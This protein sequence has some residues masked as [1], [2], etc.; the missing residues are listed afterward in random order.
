MHMYI[1]FL[2]MSEILQLHSGLDKSLQSLQPYLNRLLWGSRC[3]HRLRRVNLW[4]AVRF[5]SHPSK[6]LGPAGVASPMIQ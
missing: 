5:P 6:T 1:N 3:Q 2:Y 4:I